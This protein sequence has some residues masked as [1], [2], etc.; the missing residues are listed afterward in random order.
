M[1][2]QAMPLN[3]QEAFV[4]VI[5]AASI[6]ATSILVRQLADSAVLA[7]AAGQEI[8]ETVRLV[9]IVLLAIG[10]WALILNSVALIWDLIGWARG[11]ASADH[12]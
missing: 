7:E 5:L 9:A 4:R 11:R 1:R 10:I 2:G 12:G 8:Q 3:V 6:I